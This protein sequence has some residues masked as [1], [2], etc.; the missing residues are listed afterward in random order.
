MPAAAVFAAGNSYLGL[1]HQASHSHMEQAA[2]AN[3]LRKRGHAVKGD[4]SK[5][6]RGKH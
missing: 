3:V 2:I 1:V 5:I 6:Y 4:L